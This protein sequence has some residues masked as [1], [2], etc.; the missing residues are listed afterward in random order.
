MER[1][2]SAFHILG[3]NQSFARVCICNRQLAAGVQC[4]CG[5]ALFNRRRGD[6]ADRCAI[7]DTSDMDSDGLVNKCTVLI[8]GTDNK[9]IGLI[10]TGIE[11]LHF[12]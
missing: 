1:T 10:S 11:G 6:R 9:A 4:C 12:G 7:V 3:H 8:L 2:V 5:V